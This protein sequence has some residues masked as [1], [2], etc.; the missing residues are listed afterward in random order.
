[1][2]MLDAP[3]FIA[4]GNINPSVFVKI[5]STINFGV[6]QAAAATDKIFGVSDDGTYQPPGVTGS[7]GY[8]AHQNQPIKVYAD[9]DVALITV[10]VA[11]ITAG[12]YLKS[13]ANGKAVTVVF[14]L[15]AGTIF[16][17]GQTLESANPGELA[18]M[19][20]RV[21]ALPGATA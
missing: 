6:I 11:A 1:M 8:A 4:N 12:D 10:G 13:D 7:D 5:D 9:G 17:G 20:V 2:P 3:A 14:T 18:R 15:G 21:Q 16:A 19:F